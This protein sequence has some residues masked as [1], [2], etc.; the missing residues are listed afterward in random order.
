SIGKVCRNEPLLMSAD[1]AGHGSEAKVIG[2]RGGIV[3]ID[4]SQL[5][6]GEQADGEAR[7]PGNDAAG[8]RVHSEPRV[9]GSKVS[10]YGRRWLHKDL[11]LETARHGV[12]PFE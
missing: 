7:Q 5:Q 3:G 8:P 11:I 1:K 6:P 2:Y 10:G 4:W 9:G 12:P